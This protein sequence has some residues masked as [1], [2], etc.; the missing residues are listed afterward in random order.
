MAAYT[1]L[2]LLFF[3]LLLAIPLFS[4]RRA[5]IVYAVGSLVLPYLH[6][7]GMFIR[8]EL[9]YAVWLFILLVIRNAVKGIPLRV[10]ETVVLYLAYLLVVSASTMIALVGVPEQIFASFIVL[11]GLFRP[12]LVLLVFANASMDASFVRSMIRIFLG[13]SVGI[14][15]FSV[16]QFLGVEV[17]TRITEQCYLSPAVSGPFEFLLAV[18]GRLIRPMSVFESPVYNANYTLIVILVCFT[19]LQTERN[20]WLRGSLYLAGILAAIAGLMTSSTT[21]LLGIMVLVGI[22]IWTNVRFPRRVVSLA[23]A[24]VIGGSAVFC[25]FRSSPALQD[26]ARGGLAYQAQRITGLDLFASR[27][28][29]ESGIL[30]ETYSA[31]LRNPLIGNGALKAGEAFVGD[32]T[33]VATLYMGGLVG[34]AIYLFFLYWVLKLSSSRRRLPRGFGL[35]NSLVFQMT[36]LLLVTGLAAPAFHMRRVSEF[37][38][39]LLGMSFNRSLREDMGQCT[40]DS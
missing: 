8:F 17:A 27:Y 37:Y 40:I 7:G 30:S 3:L 21:F 35:L 36:L 23:T 1:I 13:V 39:L 5:L 6:I 14:N 18:H 33:Y 25:T 16:T 32:S 29:P 4:L 15:V 28:A 38:W 10:H 22:A 24:V 20:M 19:L 26:L 2:I 31:I 9:I 34:L 11:Y 12:L